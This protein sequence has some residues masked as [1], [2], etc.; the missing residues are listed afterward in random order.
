MHKKTILKGEGR[1]RYNSVVPCLPSTPEVLG[2]VLSNAHTHTMEG[3]WLIS[4]W[5]VIFNV[6]KIYMRLG[7]LRIA[8]EQIIPKVGSFK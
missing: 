2:L 7:I 4:I 6:L 3:G 1:W 8:M 5:K